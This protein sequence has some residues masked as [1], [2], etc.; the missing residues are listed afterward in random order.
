MLGPNPNQGRADEWVLD[1][2]AR[3]RIDAAYADI[4]RAQET[5]PRCR[6]CGQRSARLDGRGSCSRVTEEHRRLV[7]EDWKRSG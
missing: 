3:A 1:E 5:M 6:F 2:A 4:E 7:A